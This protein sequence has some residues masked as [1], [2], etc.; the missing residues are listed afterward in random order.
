MSRK[1]CLLRSTRPMAAKARSQV[2]QTLL[3]MRPFDL[4]PPVGW[5]ALYQPASSR[6]QASPAFWCHEAHGGTVRH[7]FSLYINQTSV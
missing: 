6:C 7:E 2:A 3:A 1:V 4:T 5:D